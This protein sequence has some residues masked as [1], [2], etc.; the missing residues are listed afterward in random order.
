M[1][2][3]LRDWVTQLPLRAQG[4]LLTGVRGCDLAP[5]HASDNAPERDLVAHLR[6]VVLHNADERETD[7][8]GAWMRT[9]PPEAW[10][11]SMFGH[12][13]LHWYSHLMH[14]YEI[15]GYMHPDDSIGEPAMVV[16]QRLATGLHLKPE[17]EDELQARLIEDRIATG[18]VVS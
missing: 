15:V 4:T 2:S 16:Y 14:A 12:Y 17:T 11:P 8:P 5:K 7:I 18:T 3:V 6:W 1:T 9:R 10:R 13:P